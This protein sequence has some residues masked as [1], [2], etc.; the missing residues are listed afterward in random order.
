MN[1]DVCDHV[2]LLQILVVLR[3][4]TKVVLLPVWLL[5]VHLLAVSVGG[6]TVIHDLCPDLTTE[7]LDSNP[8]PIALLYRGET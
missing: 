7:E 1:V 6:I 3:R 8:H 2:L 5:D 4:N